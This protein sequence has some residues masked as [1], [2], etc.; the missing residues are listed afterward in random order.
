MKHHMYNYVR[1]DK[2]V[3]VKNS[4]DHPVKWDKGVIEKRL[5]PLSKF[6]LIILCDSQ[7]KWLC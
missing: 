6:M 4:S 2:N 1:A 5:G 3:L 7:L